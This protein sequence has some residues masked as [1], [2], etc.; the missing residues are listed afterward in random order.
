MDSAFRFGFWFERGMAEMLKVPDRVLLTL[1]SL[2]LP[3]LLSGGFLDRAPN[4]LAVGVAYPL[5]QA[6]A[7][8]ATAAMIGF[9]GLALNSGPSQRSWPRH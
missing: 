3:V 6:P 7:L 4:R 1:F 2:G 8:E 5:S 9:C